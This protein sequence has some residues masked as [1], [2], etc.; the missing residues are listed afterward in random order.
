MYVLYLLL[1]CELLGVSGIGHDTK[2]IHHIIY[3]PKKSRGPKSEL[4]LFLTGIYV[5]LHVDNH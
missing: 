4:L 3:V 5:V 1:R 2:V